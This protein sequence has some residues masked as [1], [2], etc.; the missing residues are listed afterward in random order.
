MVKTRELEWDPEKSRKNREKH[1]IS[2]FE[3]RELWRGRVVEKEVRA[4]NDDSRH[5][6]YGMIGGRH[7]TAIV[8]YRGGV[9]RIISARRSR[10]KE[11]VEYDSLTRR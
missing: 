8:T 5:A 1:G 11:R 2:F 7:W 6:V 9:T 10:M 3:A 4:G